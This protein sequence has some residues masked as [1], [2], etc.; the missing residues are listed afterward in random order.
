MATRHELFISHSSEDKALAAELCAELE[1]RGFSC[2][3]APRD[4]EPGVEYSQSLN[5]A[6]S[7]TLIFLL[8]LS[9]NA[10]RVKTCETRVRGCR[11]QGDSDYTCANP[12]QGVFRYPGLLHQYSAMV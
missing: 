11:S 6:I 7:D 2:W 4:I 9:T 10:N 1:W 12:E 3:I 5:A 8:V